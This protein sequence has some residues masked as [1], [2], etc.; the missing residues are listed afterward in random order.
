MKIV[1]ETENLFGLTRFGMV[2]CFLV[3]E[4]DGLTLVD[5]NLPGTARVIL[6]TAEKLCSPIRR[7]LLTHA[8]FDHTGSVENLMAALPEIEL[9]IGLREQRLLAGDLSLDPQESGK[10]LIGFARVSAKPTRVLS[11][12]DRVGSLEAI[13][14]PGHTPG[15]MAF[16]DVRD[17]SLIAGDSFTTQTGLVAAGVFSIVFPFPA[18]F[19]WNA[20]LAA[21]SAA[22]LRSLNPSL[23]C[24]GHGRTLVSPLTEMDRAIEVAFQQHPRRNPS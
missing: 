4:D 2:N 13:S 24:V 16:R 10:K 15:H 8:H 20:T 11:D 12:S 6:G 14:C 22:R 1:Q 7:I 19:S 18:W 23:L 21:E 9:M 5:T 17:N 3:R